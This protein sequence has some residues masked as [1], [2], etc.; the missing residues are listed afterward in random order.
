MKVQADGFE[1]EFPG[2]L[3]AFV[4]DDKLVLPLLVDRDP[5]VS[6]QVGDR[7]RLIL[8]FVDDD[9]EPVIKLSTRAYPLLKLLEAADRE[10]KDLLW[11]RFSGVFI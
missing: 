6:Q 2:A 4:F 8:C 5:D 3:D 1:F 11:E 9:D 10:Q 7:W